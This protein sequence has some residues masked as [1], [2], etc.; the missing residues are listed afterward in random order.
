MQLERWRHAN[1]CGRW[2]NMARSTTTHE[3][4][5]VYKVGDDKPELPK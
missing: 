1:G 4:V 3:I 5:A 2:F